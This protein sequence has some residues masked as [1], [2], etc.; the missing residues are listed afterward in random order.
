MCRAK[1]VL[2]PTRL[3]E[4]F[5]QRVPVGRLVAAAARPVSCARGSRE[6][7]SCG[8]PRTP[9]LQHG[10]TA[11]S[12]GD[13]ARVHGLAKVVLPVQTKMHLNTES[14]TK[15]DLAR[16]DAPSHRREPL[17]C[18]LLGTEMDAPEVEQ[19]A[20]FRALSTTQQ[21]D[22][23]VN[24]LQQRY[25]QESFVKKSVFLFRQSPKAT[26]NRRVLCSS[27]ARDPKLWPHAY[28]AHDAS[29]DASF[30]K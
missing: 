14:S 19:S 9:R 13:A 18:L 12:H 11:A 20:W 28:A 22:A 27:R 15:V 1:Q 24:V 30:L 10:E 26:K 2:P 16:C 6:A 25:K 5:P 8:A 21:A 3:H 7:K 29:E 17:E 4:G 23:C